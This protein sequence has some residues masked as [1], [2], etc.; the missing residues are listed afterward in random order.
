MK[1]Y[2]MKF[3]ESK[4]SAKW[5]CLG[6]RNVKLGKLKVQLTHGEIKK[7]FPGADPVAF[8]NGMLDAFLGDPFRYRL[9]REEAGIDV[10]NGE[11][12]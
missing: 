9:N 11:E 1:R 12:K 8:A 4:H 10:S 2:P 5:F 6:Y 3:K 7:L